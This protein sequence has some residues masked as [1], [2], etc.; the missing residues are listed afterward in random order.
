[1]THFTTNE[2]RQW[3][4]DMLKNDEATITF[5]KTN[6]EQRTMHCTLKE[7]IVVPYEKKT[8][9]TKNHSDEVIAVWDLEKDAWRSFRLDSITEVKFVLE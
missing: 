4:V 2:G 3:L 6:G 5:T 8:E 1:M 7:S 9:R